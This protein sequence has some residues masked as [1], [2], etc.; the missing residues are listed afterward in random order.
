MNVTKADTLEVPGA[1]LY[2]EMRGSGPL[3]PMLPGAQGDAEYS[4]AVTDHL[5]G[6]YTI[7]SY[8]R[9]GLSRSTLHGSAEGPVWRRMATM[10]TA[11]WP[12]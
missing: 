9:R 1:S 7:V 10:P 3:L 6:C 5:V 11:C 12:T 2:Y 4:N 8:D